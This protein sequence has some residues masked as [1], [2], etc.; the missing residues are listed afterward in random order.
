MTHQDT[1]RD[2]TRRPVPIPCE[3]RPPAKTGFVRE[4]AVSP[5]ETGEMDLAFQGI[6]IRCQCLCSSVLKQSGAT[7]T[8]PSDHDALSPGP[9]C[10]PQAAG[11]GG[12]TPHSTSCVVLASTSTWHQ[13][14][15]SA[16]RAA[17]EGICVPRKIRKIHM[18]NIF[19]S[20]VALGGR[21]FGT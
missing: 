6:F 2:G 17:V 19:P 11:T 20:A 4:P 10:C 3:T 1:S 18:L 9:C 12:A 5:A 7:R 16:L 21:S 8:V 14:A 15:N 13:E